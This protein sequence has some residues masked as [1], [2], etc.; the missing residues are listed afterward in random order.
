MDSP[1][2]LRE[3]NFQFAI[4]GLCLLTLH[5]YLYIRMYWTESWSGSDGGAVPLTAFEVR[6]MTEVQML[7]LVHANV[8]CWIH[9]ATFAPFHR[10]RFVFL[11]YTWVLLAFAFFMLVIQIAELSRT[12]QYWWHHALLFLLWMGIFGTSSITVRIWLLILC[13]CLWEKQK[14]NRPPKNTLH[15]GIEQL[16]HNVIALDTEFGDTERADVV[17]QSITTVPVANS[18]TTSRRVIVEP[19]AQTHVVAANVPF[20]F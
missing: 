7:L 11:T 12:Q 20:S 19:V 1:E 5:I 10:R 3:T 8:W 17:L 13:P 2:L 6:M 16:F 14:R 18:T 4:S 9:L 15:S